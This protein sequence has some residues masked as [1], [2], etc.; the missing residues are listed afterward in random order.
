M[1]SLW[2][3]LVKGLLLNVVSNYSVF[4]DHLLQGPLPLQAMGLRLSVIGFTLNTIWSVSAS[5]NRTNKI[6]RIIACLEVLWCPCVLV[7]RTDSLTRCNITWVICFQGCWIYLMSNCCFFLFA[8][9][10]LWLQFPR[11]KKL[12]SINDFSSWETT[13]SL[14]N[15][16]SLAPHK[17]HSYGFVSWI[18]CHWSSK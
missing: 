9:D 7:S 14:L 1:F 12:A 10:V 17:S 5:C 6:N 3:P 4:E 16:N 2:R 18:I 13:A 15:A 8:L 11:E